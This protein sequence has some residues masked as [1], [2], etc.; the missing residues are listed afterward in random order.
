MTTIREIAKFAGV[1]VA[2][3]SRVLNNHPYVS[4]EKKAAVSHAVEKLN[5][6]RNLKAIQLSNKH[7]N[8]VGIILPK[9]DLPYFSKIVEGLAE[10]ARNLHLQLVLI[11]SNYDIEKE[12]EALEL[13]R[14]HLMDGIIFCSRAIS[15][16]EVRAYQEFGPIILLEDTD[17]DDFYSI[18]IPHDHAFTYGLDYLYSKGHKKIAIALNR[19]DGTN[20]KKRIQAYES[21]MQRIK[22][23]I[24]TEWIFD[25]CLSIEDG[26]SLMDKYMAL[27]DK[28]TAFLTTNDQIA[29]GVL[30]AADKHQLKIPQDLAVL[31]FDNQEISK[32]MDLSTISIPIKEMGQSAM[33]ALFN[34]RENSLH[35][36][37][38][39]ELPF[40]LIE[41]LTV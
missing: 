4:Q 25:Q 3:V 23:P 39:R 16:S 17:Q 37:K 7:S 30:L 9:I 36:S 10:E 1:S 24:R 20:S 12:R 19:I 18:S 14:G 40:K 27:N 38:K 34:I 29:A 13:L 26:A 33:R 31:S 8:L 28:P 6:S 41:R 11:Q 21:M 15:L 22:E 32:V 2:T 5:Y 35:A